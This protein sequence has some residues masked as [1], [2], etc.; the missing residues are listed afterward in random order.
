MFSRLRKRFTYTNV[1]MTL[2][3]VFA[4]TGGAYAASKYLITSTK[5]I[6][7]KVLKSLKGANGKSGAN[8]ANGAQGPAGPTGATG[9]TGT[10][11]PGA[12]GNE[13]K[14]GKEG[15]PGKNG[16]NGTTGFTKT[17]PEN[18]TETG[19][20]AFG[21][22]EGSSPI[23]T[24]AIASFAIPLAAP[25]TEPAAE[26]LANPVAPSCHVHLIDT[27]GKELHFEQPSTSPTECG[28]PVGTVAEPKA[29]SGHLC[30][31]I[32]GLNNAESFSEGF[33]KPGGGEGAGTTGAL[34]QV[35]LKVGIA[36]NGFGSW[37]VTG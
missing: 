26:C 2:A 19:A 9:A 3:L 11:T 12:T 8:G 15:P 10:G 23:A 7:P 16:K 35:L 1:A 18:E 21:P 33:L 20:W 36:G 27:A 24:V 22:M 14:E 30:V 31:Y 32:G 5:Q 25:L 29:A 13:G 17:L 37:A 28:T 6:S 4:M 34:L